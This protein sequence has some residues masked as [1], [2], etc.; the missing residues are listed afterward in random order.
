MSAAN[1]AFIT[2]DPT[3]VQSYKGLEI[4]VT[5]RLS[6]RWQMLAG[7]TLSKNRQDGYSADVSPNLLINNNGNITTPPTRIGRTSSS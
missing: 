7:Y 5:K 3:L 4:T 6:H 2:N 1:P